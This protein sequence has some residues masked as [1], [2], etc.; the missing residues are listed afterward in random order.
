MRQN[1]SRMERN[2]N[3]A[4]KKRSDLT[5]PTGYNP[6]LDKYIESFRHMVKSTILNT[7]K[8]Q[9]SKIIPQEMKAIQSL[10][11]NKEIIIYQQIK[12]I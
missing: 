1:P 11:N 5:F 12:V 8:R 2:R 9:L 3:L 7:S 6:H 10:K 4:A